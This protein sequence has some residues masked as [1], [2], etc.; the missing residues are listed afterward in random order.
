[1]RIGATFKKGRQR[2][3]CVGLRDYV[4]QAGYES[5]L[6]VLK[7]RC[8]ECGALF[9]FMTTG[10]K[11]KKREVNRRCELHRQP[12]IRIEQRRRTPADTAAETVRVLDR[13]AHDEAAPAE[14]RL[15][16]SKALLDFAGVVPPACSVECGGGEQAAPNT[17]ADFFAEILG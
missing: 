5:R 2:Y 12:G 1:M 14:I 6:I 8:A 15:E 10:S 17:G 3:E 9:E 13:I 4:N 16:A 7:S 11:V